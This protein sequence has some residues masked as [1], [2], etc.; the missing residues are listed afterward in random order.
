MNGETAILVE[1]DESGTVAIMAGPCDEQ[2]FLT[3]DMSDVVD[4]SEMV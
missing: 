2:R 4:L 3:C 1:H